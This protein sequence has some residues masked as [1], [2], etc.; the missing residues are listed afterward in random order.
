M[1]DE[2][3]IIELESRLTHLDD[4]VEQL[5]DIVSAQQRKLD[6]LE[7]LI[8]QSIEQQQDL[9]DQLAPEL[10]DSPPPHY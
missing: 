5:N 2:Q 7:R 9:K 1:T 6:R 10:N 4:T 8:Q 3:R